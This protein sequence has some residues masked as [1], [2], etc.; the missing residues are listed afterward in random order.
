L[1]LRQ[2]LALLGVAFTSALAVTVTGAA[3]TRGAT[4]GGVTG[5]CNKATALKLAVKHDYGEPFGHPIISFICGPFTGP[6]SIAMAGL[7][8]S[9]TCLPWQGFAVFHRVAGVWKQVMPLTD[10]GVLKITRVGSAIKETSPVFN[11]GD[12]RCNPSGGEHSR[13]WHWNGKRLVA[14][15]W[16]G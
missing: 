15:A 12:F 14:G 6:G 13:T 9:G 2:R 10:F 4:A 16:S 11:A 8:H 5:S 3:G 7:Y 1:R